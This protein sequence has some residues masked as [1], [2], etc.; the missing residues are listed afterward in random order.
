MIAKPEDWFSR[1]EAHFNSFSLEVSSAADA[2]IRGPFSDFFSRQ[3]ML[4]VPKKTCL[5]KYPHP[6]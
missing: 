1:V 6:V 5:T 4:R 2:L 3:N